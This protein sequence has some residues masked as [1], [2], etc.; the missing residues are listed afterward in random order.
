M[1]IGTSEPS[2]PIA[3]QQAGNITL[4]QNG[5]AIFPA[6]LEAI[7]GAR[8]TICFETFIYWKGKIAEEVAEALSERARA[9]V[10]VHVLLDWVGTFR[11]DE[12]LIDLM[13]SGGVEVEKFRPLRWFNLRRVNY[14]T[15][16]KLLIVDGRIGFT[17]G[18]GVADEW[19][20]HA[21]D[22][23]HWRDNHYR[24]TGAA[25]GELQRAFFSNWVKVHGWKPEPGS[26]VYYP[27]LEPTPCLKVISGSPWSNRGQLQRM[28]LEAIDSANESIRIATAYFMP[29]EK[30][31]RALLRA[32][33]RSVHIEILMCGVHTDRDI[34]RQ[35]SRAH[36]GR[37]LKAGVRLFEYEP[38][39]YHVK[40]LVVDSEW[41][42]IGSANFDARS[43][44]LNDELNVNVH[45]KAVVREHITM[46]QEDLAKGRKLSLVQW[47]QRPVLTKIGDWISQLFRRQL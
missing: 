36:W 26:D 12:A 34:V 38:T 21:Q 39:L 33:K 5:D 35:A 29:G 7:H 43:C 14:R 17:G 1:T 13:L 28:F 42:S 27:E 23:E 37:L 3:E 22:P 24:L 45:E 2:L 46:F 15:H 31:F 32:R 18:V 8:Y 6:M 40:L 25:V 4:L 9:G 41:I 44:W 47:E 16:R 10:A 11:M 20:G 19:Q 30:L